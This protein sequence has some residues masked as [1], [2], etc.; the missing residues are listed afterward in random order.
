MD[1]PYMR[2]RPVT[3]GLALLAIALLLLGAAIRFQTKRASTE[4]QCQDPKAF[5]ND[6]N[7]SY[8][9][10]KLP[11]DTVVDYAEHDEKTLARTTYEDGHFHITF[12]PRLAGSARVVHLY[13][14]HEMCHI[15]TWEEEQAHGPEWKACMHAVVAKGGIIEQMIESYE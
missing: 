9:D 6:F 5:Y 3:G 13:S 8:F 1:N 10:G 11:K 12:N 15:A 4:P 7:L 14:L 2:P